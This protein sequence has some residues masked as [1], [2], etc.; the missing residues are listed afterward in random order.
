MAGSGEP[1]LTPNFLEIIRELIKA[2]HQIGLLTNFSAPVDKIEKF[3]EITKGNLFEF[4][5]SLHLERANP[6]KFLEKAVKIKKLAGD[7]FSVRSVVR[8][9][10]VEELK[11]IAQMFQKKGIHFSMQPERDHG[12]EKNLNEESFV[13]YNKKELDIIRDFRGEFS[14]RDNLKL[15]GKR[16]W[17]GSKYFV[18]NED[19]EAWQCQ[20]ARRYKN[21]KGY[22]GNLL[23]GDFK[24]RKSPLPCR[25][26]YCYCLAAIVNN[27]VNK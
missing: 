27:I 8:K 5:V 12:D 4:G 21:T 20:P 16:C 10:Q 13:N 25:Y 22:L 6:E 15:K 2:G 26:K 11:K 14:S 9:G 18:I 19:G 7:S 1:L 23:R 3:C 17:A 24:L